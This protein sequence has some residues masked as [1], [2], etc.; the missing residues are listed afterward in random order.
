MKR[1]AFQSALMIFLFAGAAWGQGV[2][3]VVNPP[4]PV[5]LPR[6]IPRPPSPP[7]MTYKIKELDY[8]AKI[9][10]QVAQVAVTQ[11]FVNT[12]SR[13]MEVSFVFP[14][15]YDGAIDRMTFM[16]D[17]KEYDAKLLDAKEARKTYEEHVRKSQDPALL[18]WLGYGMFKTSVFPVPP[19]AE[20]KVS[21]KFS[22]LLRKDGKLTD[23]IIP[24]STAK[25]TSS[26][27]EKLSIHAAIETTHEMKDVYSPTHAVSIE[28][29]D[30]KHAVVKLEAKDTIPTNDFR[31]LFDSADGKLG[32]S[33][34]SYRPDKDDE[35][36]FL[37]LASP[38][39]KA[40]GDERPAK[41]VIFVVD[42]SGSMS[43]KKIEQAKEAL[44]FVLNN[45]RT[46]DTFN[47]VAYDSTVESFR[48]ELQKY[49]DETRKAALGFVEGLFAGG[50]T[51]ID[52]ALSTALGMI[53]DESR[54]NF[55]LFLT[56]GIPTVGEKNEAKIAANARQKNKLRT[57]LSNFGVG[58]DVNSR[59]L[60][61]LIRDN[62]GQS[63]YV[64]PDENIESHVSRVYGK[65]GAP[66]M[67]SVAVKVDIEG[68]S[69]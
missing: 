48:P 46:G 68:A 44:K 57:R 50:S 62:Y 36:F 37:L 18:E 24:L 34:I 53:K 21:L 2:L 16:V 40:A 56:D 69:E 43:G 35:G 58:Y 51:N 64:R 30:S 13:Q 65:L 52:G 33:V 7:P 32:A 23:L 1:I 15:P 9:T 25:Y 20:R 27:V 8:H 10:D 60:D 59:V 29:P 63:E 19:G 61:R 4:H 31:L 45:L 12:G 39:I 6:P 28:R 5:P 66:V 41:T 14:V 38:E 54:P 67:T 3:L 22:Q 49:D 47:I 55:I 17:G 42:R 11:T 26:P